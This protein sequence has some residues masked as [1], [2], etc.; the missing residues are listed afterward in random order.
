MKKLKVCVFFV[1]VAVACIGSVKYRIESLEAQEKEVE[2]IRENTERVQAER[3][4]KKRE[5]EDKKSKIE[6]LLP[7]FICW[8]DSLTV[9]VGGE[10]VTYPIILQR[11]IKENVYDIP[12]KN[13]GVSNENAVTVSAR[14]G[15][16][17]FSIYGLTIPS[18][19]T[20]VR[21]RFKSINGH[22]LMPLR[23]EKTG[24]NPVTIEGIEGTLTISQD[25]SYSDEYQY[26]FTRSTAGEETQILDDMELH[27]ASAGLYNKYIPIIAIGENGGYVD[28]NDLITQIH[29]IAEQHD[30]N[31]KYIV[32]GITIGTD[33]TNTVLEDTMRSEFGQK[34]INLRKYLC[35]SGLEDCGITPTEEDED[36]ILIGR[37]PASLRSDDIHLNSYGYTAVAQ[38]IYERMERL[39]YFE[40]IFSIL[41][42]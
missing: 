20:P 17:A 35:E 33:D 25:S 22:A 31:G 28:Y 38:G 15:S 4:A 19:R 5:E 24:I 37:V 11:L 9:G 39:G 1:I 7:G 27:I 18:E 10:G 14:A 40:E 30:T 42:E 34:Y 6:L 36:N 32:L 16:L 8:G 12:V 21:I 23:Q 13:M 3:E 41:A 26:Y 2:I 29:A